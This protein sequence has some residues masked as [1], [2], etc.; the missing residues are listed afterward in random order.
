MEPGVA[1]GYAGADFWKKS[2]GEGSRTPVPGD[3]HAN[4]YMLIR[5]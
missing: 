3:V 1:F 2:G 5:P 4:D